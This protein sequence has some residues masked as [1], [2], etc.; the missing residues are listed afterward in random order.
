MLDPIR[1]GNFASRLSHSCNA[2]CGT[3]TS[4]ANQKYFVGM[5]ALNNIQYGE[6]LTFDYCSVTNKLLVLI[7]NI[8]D[9]RI[10]WV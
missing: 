4:V 3:I 10:K 9:W 7:N 1:K 5:Y 6:E 8:G 2:N